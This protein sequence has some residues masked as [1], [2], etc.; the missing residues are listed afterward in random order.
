MLR[1]RTLLFCLLATAIASV[2][3]AGLAQAAP[4]NST[5]TVALR[6]RATGEH[7]VTLTQAVWTDATS[8]TLTDQ[9][10]SCGAT[11]TD[12]GSG[13]TTYALAASDVGNTI[14]VVETATATDGTATANCRSDRGRDRPPALWR[15]GV[16][17]RDGPTGGDAHCQLDR[18]EQQ[19]DA[20]LRVV[21]L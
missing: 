1:C 7:T 17:L 2:M 6:H 16:N 14:E 15:I 11:C 21:E 13:G 12:V 10:E 3:L 19:P 4:T 20:H 9:W 18:M 5:A 8:V